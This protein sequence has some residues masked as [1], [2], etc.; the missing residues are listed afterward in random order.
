MSTPPCF[1]IKLLDS[2]RADEYVP[3]ER[4]SEAVYYTERVT[5]KYPDAVS[6]KRSIR[7]EF[8]YFTG[9]KTRHKTLSQL[10]TKRR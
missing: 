3:A 5:Y 2:D 4:F 6:P 9:R 8:K 7:W 10:I 1:K